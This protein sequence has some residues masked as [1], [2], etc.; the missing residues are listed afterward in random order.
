MILIQPQ[1]YMIMSWVLNSLEITTKEYIRFSIVLFCIISALLTTIIIKITNRITGSI[2][3]TVIKI[4]FF[5]KDKILF[6]IKVEM[7]YL[8]F[9]ISKSNK[10]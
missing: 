8:A 9:N 2:D 10:C 4:G 3:N 7:T 5:Y 1:L 6:S